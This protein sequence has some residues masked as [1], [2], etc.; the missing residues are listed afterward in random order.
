MSTVINTY[1]YVFMQL[2]ID[3]EFEVTM[4]LCIPT[5]DEKN[6]NITPFSLEEYEKCTQFCSSLFRKINDGDLSISN[7][8]KMALWDLV[9]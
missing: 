5:C 9:G 2:Y 6:F 8:N 7:Q 1:L 3:Y 4:T